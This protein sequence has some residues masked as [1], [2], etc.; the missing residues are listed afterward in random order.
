MSLAQ[1]FNFALPRVVF[2]VTLNQSFR[3]LF[4]LL[5]NSLFL[6]VQGQ[7]AFNCFDDFNT[8]FIN[9]FFPLLISASC[10]KMQVLL[11]IVFS[12]NNIS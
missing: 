12:D 10:L 1:T 6:S 5:T 11:H 7:Q 8:V 9:K 3:L 2:L 4:N